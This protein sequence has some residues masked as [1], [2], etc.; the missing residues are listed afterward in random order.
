MGLRMGVLSPGAH[1]A[2]TDVAGVR[3]GQTTVSWGDGALRPGHGPARTGVT[4]ILPH[5]GNLFQEKVPAAIHVINGFG[6][7]TGLAQV[8]ELGTIETPIAL[9][10]TLC[11][12][13][14]ADA[15]ITHAIGQNPEIGVTTS[16]VNPVV[17]ECSDAF[18]NDIQGRH[19][20]EEHVLAA[21]AAASGGAVEE[22]A[23]GAGTGMMA[24][25]YKGGIG[26]ASRVIDSE[27]GGWTVGALVLANFGQRHQ[28]VIDGIPIGRLLANDD[29]ATP[30][31]GSIM[32]VLAT[33]APLLDRGLKRI[34]RRAGLGLARTGSIAGHGSGDVVI[35]FS[36][37]PRV[38]IPHAATESILTLE[39]VAENGPAD[40]ASTIDALFTA[41]IEAT[42]EAVI[43]A[44]FAAKTTVG[45][46]GNVG[47]AL[48]LARVRE[49][50]AAH[51][52]L[53]HG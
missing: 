13:K 10:S 1:N 28:L 16:T 18:L 34:A 42:E 15:L 5:G 53:S 39:M 26:T 8:E 23:V 4:V 14:V 31:R 47:D 38:R 19:V 25:H 30:E 27:L 52:R 22:G 45:R 6:K 51:G 12:G 43:N 50:L 33:D 36:T 40:Q 21:I 11:V 44:L 29:D 9:T 49:I 17:G 35:A 41:T 24:F 7:T 3:V 2:I 37:A 48:P 32:I 20:R 46:D